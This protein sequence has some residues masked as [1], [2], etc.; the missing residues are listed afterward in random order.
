METN[1]RRNSRCPCGSGKKFKKC[2]LGK[3]PRSTRLHVALGQ[4]IRGEDTKFHV[5]PRTG[6]IEIFNRG[7]KVIPAWTAWEISYKRDSGKDKAT[8]LLPIPDRKL[9]TRQGHIIDYFDLLMFVDTNYKTVGQEQ[10]CVTSAIHFEVGKPSQGK[11]QR[12]FEFGGFMTEFRDP[13]EDPEKLGWWD[14]ISRIPHGINGWSPSMKIGIVVDSHKSELA[15]INARS[16]PL[17]ANVSLLSGV[18]LIYASADA[19][20]D[21]IFNQLFHEAD[22]RS[23]VLLDHIIANPHNNWDPNP[24]GAPFRLRRYW[25][26]AEIYKIFNVTPPTERSKLIRMPGS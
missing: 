22:G 5:D 13:T 16:I 23:K 20:N 24:T 17:I 6:E 14:L 7:V 12:L 3:N 19:Q 1:P 10:I 25:P 21:S 26:N 2:C 15:D 18:T 11:E 4:T 9:R 8:V